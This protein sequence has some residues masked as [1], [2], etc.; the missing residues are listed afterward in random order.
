[1][2]NCDEVVSALDVTIKTQVIN[3]LLDLQDQLG[4]SYQ[5]V[6]YNL[7]TVERISH[8]ITVMYLAEV[9]E[10][11]SHKEVFENIMHSYTKSYYLQFRSPIRD[12]Y[13]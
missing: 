9:V 8:R 2:I 1:M 13:G 5:L 4:Y 6:S 3:I 11:G 10:I 7:A 12:W